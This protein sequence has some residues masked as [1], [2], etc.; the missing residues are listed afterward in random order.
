MMVFMVGFT[1]AQRTVTGTIVDSEGL[2]LI[3]ANVTV[4]NTT[5]GTITDI[6]GNFSLSVPADTKQLTVSYTGFETSMIDLNDESNYAIIL[7]E[8]QIL[9]EI[10]VTAGGLEKNKARIGYAIQN[11][12]ADEIVGARETNIVNALN[13]KV[14]GVQVTSSAGSPG[15]SSS[16]RIRGSVSVNKS[17]QPQ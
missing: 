2:T 16:I 15:A 3:G 1:I 4:P 11:V 8:G 17:N 14:A 5:I 10:V 9:D 12:D 13:S 7:R 6:D